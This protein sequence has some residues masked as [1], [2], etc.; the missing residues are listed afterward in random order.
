MKSFAA[1]AAAAIV[2]VFSASVA[3]AQSPSEQFGFGVS[4]G[5]G[6]V[7]GHAAYAITPAFHIGTQLGLIVSDGNNQFVLAPYGKFLFSGPKELKPYLWAQFG[8]ATGQAQG[9]G[10]G[11]RTG[12]AIGGG[13]EYF[14]TPNVGIF[15]QIAVL[16]L[17]FGD[18]S[19]TNFGLLSPR[20]GIEWFLD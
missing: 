9:T 19:Y 4:A 2:S 3:S 13:A 5:D 8:I 15:G 17:G 1:F 18:F 12:L 20:V 11:T 10:T 7:G 16:D 14:A 6:M